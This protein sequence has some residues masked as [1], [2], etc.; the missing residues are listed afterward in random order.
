MTLSEEVIQ[1]LVNEEAKG[2]D[3]RNA[4]SWKLMLSFL[5]QK[6][7]PMNTRAIQ[8]MEMTMNNSKMPSYTSVERSIRK[9]RAINPKWKK[10]SARKQAEIDKV[11]KEVGY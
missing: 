5:D 4:P 8:W 3:I 1:F 11:K 2:V 9:A 10:Y 7:V 6:G